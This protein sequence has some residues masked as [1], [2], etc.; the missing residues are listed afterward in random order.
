MHTKSHWHLDC[1]FLSPTVGGRRFAVAFGGGVNP[2]GADDVGANLRP[3]LAISVRPSQDSSAARAPGHADFSAVLLRGPHR[4]GGFQRRL[5]RPKTHIHKMNMSDSIFR[6]FDWLGCLLLIPSVLF[7]GKRAGTQPVAEPGHSCPIPL[8]TLPVPA[9][10][11]RCGKAPAPTSTTDL[12]TERW[13]DVPVLDNNL[14]VRGN[15]SGT[16]D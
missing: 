2:P 12:A 11:H 14:G 3:K 16:D 10:L 9:F 7:A 13:Q 15:V 4:V 8:L 5:A 1:P 6:S